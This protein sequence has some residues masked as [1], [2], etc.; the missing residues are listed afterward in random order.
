ME[1]PPTLN[2]TVSDRKKRYY[3]AHRDDPVWKAK[4]SESKKR[5]YQRNR[6]II[7]EKNLNRYYTKKA[8]EQPAPIEA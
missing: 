4:L 7:I 6:D 1:A 2:T 3:Y 8:N 5:Y